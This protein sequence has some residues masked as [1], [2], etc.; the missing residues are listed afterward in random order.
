MLYFRILHTIRYEATP[1]T[2]DVDNERKATVSKIMGT[3]EVSEMLGVS[4]ATLRAWRSRNVGPA[5]FKVGRKTV[6]M[7]GDVTAWVKDQ[8]KKTMR[9]EGVA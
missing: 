9:G 8:R 6:Y 5:N 4:Q 2:V 7:A 3:E 1:I